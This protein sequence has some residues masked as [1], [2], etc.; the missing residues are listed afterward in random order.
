MEKLCECGCGKVAPICTHT[1]VARGR[2]KGEQ[3]RFISG[4][5]GCQRKRS[6]HCPKG[7][8]LSGENAYLVPSKGTSLNTGKAYRQGLGCRICISDREKQRRSTPEGKTERALESLKKH[9]GLPPDELKRAKP[10]ILEFYKRPEEFQVCPICG[11][12]CS[13]KKKMAAD[14]SHVDKKFRA[15]ICQACNTALGHCRE[16]E[17]LLGNGKLGRYL[18]QHKGDFICPTGLYEAGIIARVIL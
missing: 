8:L 7:H 10:L 6:T 3:L 13:G 5:N 11:D 2:I 15:M 14:H 17:D 18:A 1:N 16:R 4:H 12:S 9:G